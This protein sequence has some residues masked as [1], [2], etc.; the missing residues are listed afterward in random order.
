MWIK[1]PIDFVS[2]DIS[3]FVSYQRVDVEDGIYGLLKQDNSGPSSSKPY[4]EMSELLCKLQRG[5]L[6][7]HDNLRPPFGKQVCMYNKYRKQTEKNTAK[8]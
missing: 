6:C 4:Q 7:P 3:H 5:V 8:L 2:A 1:S